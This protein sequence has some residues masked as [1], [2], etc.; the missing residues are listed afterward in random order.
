MESKYQDRDLSWLDFNNRVLNMFNPE[1]LKTGRYIGI[2]SSNLDEFISVRVGRLIKTMNKSVLTD[3]DEYNRLFKKVNKKIKHMNLSIYSKYVQVEKALEKKGYEFID[4]ND[5]SHIDDIRELFK[6]IYPLLTPFAYDYTSDFS[7]VHS[8]RLTFVIKRLDKLLFIPIDKVDRVYVLPSHP[9]KLILV[10][11]I[12][13]TCIDR[14]VNVSRKIECGVMRVI[15]NAEVSPEHIHETYFVEKM[16]KILEMRKDSSAVYLEIDSSL[17][18]S[19]LSDLRKIFN[20]SK[21]FVHCTGERVDYS[22]IQKLPIDELKVSPIAGELNS[23]FMKACSTGKMFDYIKENKSVI[24][25]HPYDSFD[26][27]ISFLYTAAK[28][29]N[30][31]DIRQTLYRVSSLDSPVIDALCLASRNGKRVCVYI[32]I[33]ARFDE[34]Q[35]IKLLDKLKENRC[36]VIH[37]IHNRKAHAKFTLVA[38][39]EDKHHRLYAHVG[40]GNYNEVTS[41]FYHDLSYITSDKNTTYELL[42]VFNSL[43]SANHELK[44]VHPTKKVLSSPHQ[45]LDRLCELID[46]EIINHKKGKPSRVFIKVNSID[47]RRIINKLYQAASTGV[48]ITIQCRGI[49]AMKP[50]VNNLSIVSTVG[51]LL[52]HDRL[53]YFENNGDPKYYLGSSD[54]LD[55]NLLYRVEILVPVQGKKSIQFIQDLVLDY[56]MGTH[57]MDP[58]GKYMSTAELGVINPQILREERR[59]T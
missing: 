8:Y 27:V 2:A 37:G 4:A 38:R 10:E 33:Q 52:E 34:A 48:P 25:E 12:I 44:Q 55:R 50:I 13:K 54:L 47:N 43:A 5:E 9:N 40:T 21:K 15:R 19:I 51:D 6:N 36:I 23:P 56:T 3:R 17:S 29:P 32:E 16:K 59:M 11:D 45:L 42:N 7:K 49:C 18:T 41:K 20:V 30:V 24:F 1:D 28:D 53:Y 39:T 22:F 46:N 58:Q 35:N 57:I 14:F 31:T 26:N